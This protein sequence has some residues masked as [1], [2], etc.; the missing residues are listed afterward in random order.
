MVLAP[1][2]RFRI[3]PLFH[4][5]ADWRERLWV[6]GGVVCRDGVALP[7]D[8]WRPCSD[9]ELDL[10]VAHEAAP[11]APGDTID[12][13]TLPAH[14][15]RWW[16]EQAEADAAEPGSQSRYGGFVGDLRDF[17]RF[18]RLAVPDGCAADVVAS[19]PGQMSI[20]VDSAG[21]LVGFAPPAPTRE[22]DAPV[23]IAVFNLGDERSHVVLLNLGGDQLRDRVAEFLMREQAYP[24]VRVAL[25]AGEGLWFPSPPPAFDGW[26]V[27]KEDLDV[28]L[29]L[30][31]GRSSSLRRW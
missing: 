9:A 7:R 25:E 5:R 13:L 2:F 11:T 29:V 22:A 3:A 27:G 1:G 4:C 24:L 14:L 15:R 30:R 28:L 19:R 18:K 26:T 6:N 16:W 12:L 8:D 31:T 21:G 23:P 17:L 10:L 20:R